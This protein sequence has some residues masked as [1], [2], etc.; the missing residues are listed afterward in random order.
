[1]YEC[2]IRYILDWAKASSGSLQ[3]LALIEFCAVGVSCVLFS[4]LQHAGFLAI[5]IC[6]YY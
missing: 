2:N 1:M 5:Y 4:K 3:Q 6:L